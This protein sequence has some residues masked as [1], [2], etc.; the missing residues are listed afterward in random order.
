[1]TLCGS[2]QA[3]SGS[4]RYEGEELVDLPSSTI[5]RKS[6]AGGPGRPPGLLPA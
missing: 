5:M 3:A 4:I 6:I 1:M 2:P